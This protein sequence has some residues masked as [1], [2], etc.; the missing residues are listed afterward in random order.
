MNVAARTRR[1]YLDRLLHPQT[2]NDPRTHMNFSASVVSLLLLAP[3]AADK[4]TYAPKEGTQIERHFEVTFEVEKKSLSMSIGGQELPKEMMDGATLTMSSTQSATVRD[5]LKKMDGA[6]VLELEREYID[7]TSKESTK[8][9]M[10]GMPDAHVEEKDLPSDLEGKSVLFTWDPKAEEHKKSWVGAGAKDDLL[11]KLQ[12]DMDLRA[13]LPDKSLSVGD[14]WTLEDT[15]LS[16]ILE[17]PGGDLAFVDEKSNGDHD[18]DFRDHLKGRA[19]FTYKGTEEAGGHRVARIAIEGK[20]TTS[21][22]I[23]ED[24][25]TGSMTFGIDFHGE[26]LWSVDEHRLASQSVEAEITVKLSIKQDVD[27]GGQEQELVLEAELEGTYRSKA[28][29]SKP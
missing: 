22:D 16:A 11:E 2:S 15:A 18:A 5:E 24:G 20:A 10:N 7:L 14:T 17:T 13:I 1:A 28:E 23:E 8:F 29:F 26:A 19:T 21:V 9:E 27:A 4:L 25:G 12:E 3:L 6:R